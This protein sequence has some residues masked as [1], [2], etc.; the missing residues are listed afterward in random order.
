MGSGDKRY[1]AKEEKKAGD[2]KR[3][4]SKAEYWRILSRKHTWARN[5]ADYCRTRAAVIRD[6]A[7]GKIYADI[8]AEAEAE[9]EKISKLSDYYFDCY[10]EERCGDASGQE[11]WEDFIHR[12]GKFAAA[13][14]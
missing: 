6:K 10:W 4:K 5:A 3:M 7:V 11:M 14:T 13:N 2:E 9:A 8:A 12:R 1:R